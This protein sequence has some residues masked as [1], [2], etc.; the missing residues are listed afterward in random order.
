MKDLGFGAMLGAMVTLGVFT[1]AMAMS[2]FS[3]SDVEGRVECGAL[4]IITSAV[5]VSGAVLGA[6]AV[7][8]ERYI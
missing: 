8:V 4:V 3:F 7:F 6:L 5:G 2:G 1:A